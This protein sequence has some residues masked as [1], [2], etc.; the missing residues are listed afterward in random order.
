MFVAPRSGKR[1][2]PRLYYVCTTH[3]KRGNTRCT[4]RHGV[5]YEGI[6]QAILGHFKHDFL[7]PVT[8]G[9]LLMSE[10]ERQQAEPNERKAQHDALQVERK[11]LDQ[12]LGRLTEAVA[13]G[14]EMIRPLVERMKMAQNQRDAVAATLEHLEGLEQ[15]RE[16]FDVVEWLSRTKTLLG[17]LQSTLESDPVA[18]RHLVRWLLPEPITVTPVEMPA[19]LVWEYLGR[20]ALDRLLTGKVPERLLPG[21]LPNGTPRPALPPGFIPWWDSPVTVTNRD[22]TELVPP[23]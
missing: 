15:V 18:G 21:S 19:G 12:E 5:P 17:D 23:G 10:W 13:L 16:D 22:A 8:L 11:R 20:G 9:E 3:H 2:K 14:G 1:G 7:N 4:N 6:T